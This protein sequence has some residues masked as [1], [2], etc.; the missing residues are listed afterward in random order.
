MKTLAVLLAGEFRTWPKCSSYLFKFFQG[1]ASRVD[2]FFATWTTSNDLPDKQI[3]DADV[4]EPFDKYR[5]NLISS[6]I[7]GPIGRK[8]YTFYN[9]AYLAKIANI[10]KREHEIRHNFV[11]DQVVETRPD[12]YIR[13]RNPHW[14]PMKDYEFCNCSYVGDHR[15]FDAIDDIYYRSNSFTNDIIANRYWHRKPKD[16]F[17]Y[18]TLSTHEMIPAWNCPHSLSAEYFNSVGIRIVKDEWDFNG[19]HLAVRQEAAN[20]DLDLYDLRELKEKYQP[21]NSNPRPKV[22]TPIIWH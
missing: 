12:I 3:T 18:S 16:S 2:Y 9:Q 13:S 20:L 6:S 21:Y 4:R 7:V 19:D 14:I 17:V 8:I 1:R 5:Q 15:G 10:L 11:Y 22:S